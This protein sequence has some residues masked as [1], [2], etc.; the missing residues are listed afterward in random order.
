MKQETVTLTKSQLVKV[1]RDER[2]WHRRNHQLTVKGFIDLYDFDQFTPVKEESSGV[3]VNGSDENPS[4]I[5]IIFKDSH[6]N[7]F[8][9][10]FSKD[11]K[12]YYA[13]GILKPIENVTHWMPDNDVKEEPKQEVT[14]SYIEEIVNIITNMTRLNYPDADIVRDVEYVLLR[15]SEAIA[16][17]EYLRR[18]EF[19]ATLF[20]NS[21]TVLWTTQEQLRGFTTQELYEQCLKKENE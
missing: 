3:W 1:L 11:T 15:E 4:C 21:E 17:G 2:D 12:Q 5:K 20:I 8:K 19:M 18:H 16:F 9:G 13:Y 14:H 6:D 10:N 7:I